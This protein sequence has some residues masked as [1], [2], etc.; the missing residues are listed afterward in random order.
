MLFQRNADYAV[1]FSHE[2]LAASP[3]A[4][5][6]QIAGNFRQSVGGSG[7]S[8][9]RFRYSPDIGRQNNERQKDGDQQSNK[10]PRAGQMRAGTKESASAFIRF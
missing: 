9:L 1:D 3:L 8:G 10:R 2:N 4:R 6:P 5:L 7:W